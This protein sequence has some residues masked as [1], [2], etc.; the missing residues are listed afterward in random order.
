[1]RPMFYQYPEEEICYG[2]DDQYMFGGDILF[3]PI[4]CQGQTERKVYLPQDNWILTKDGTRHSAG[5]VN[6][7]ADIDEFIAFVKEGSP[8][9]EAF[10]V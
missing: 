8:V 5:W 1:M 3:A 4:Y 10:S 7:H 9:Q 6:I 2:L